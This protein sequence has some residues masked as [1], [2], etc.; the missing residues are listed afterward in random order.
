MTASNWR[1]LE[2][3]G[4]DADRGLALDEALMAGVD[5]GASHPLPTLRLYTYADHV[6]LVGR[7]QTLEAEVDLDA[8]AA[9]GT[10]VGRR[11]TGGGAIVMGAAQLGVALALP[12]PATAPRL[13]IPELGEGVVAGLRRLGVDAQFGGKNDLL[14]GR[15]KIAGLGLY[16]DGRGGLLFHAS[17]LG[18]LDVGFMLRVLK[19]PAAKLAGKAVA[20][21]EDRV[22]TVVR[23]TG[24]AVGMS[25]LREAI[26]QGFADRFGVRLVP[27][28]PTDTECAAAASLV[29]SRYGNSAWV[30][31]RGARPDGTGS[32]VV[33]GSQGLV[34]V[35]VATQGLLAKNVLF[36]GDFNT[37]PDGLRKLEAALRWRR[38][39][40]ATVRELVAT[41]RNAIP[42]DEE[43]GW[44]TDEDMVG[45]LLAAGTSATQRAIAEPVRP[46]GSCYFPDHPVGHPN[47]AAGPTV[48]RSRT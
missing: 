9:S 10:G 28:K 37:V 1:L 15:R 46:Q 36:T 32:A 5:R 35:Y 17:V 39:E 22:T 8:C 41:V 44:R 14:V 21:V 45:A 33:R 6:A 27:G 18:D 11:P 20:A 30:L 29:T 4:A 48:Q 13:M 40:P 42:C 25:A 23:E 16:L 7:Y 3:D 26:A 19:I 38:M 34:R 12:A 2:D 47:P 43:L 24:T 31:E